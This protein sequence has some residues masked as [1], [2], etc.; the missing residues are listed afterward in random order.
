MILPIK[1]YGL[2]ILR[3]KS[4][5]ISKDYPN[6]KELIDDMFQTMYA[7]NGVGLSANQIGLP[8]R[9]FV[10]DATPY[11]DE[12]KELSGI[13]K[14]FINSQILEYSDDTML[15]NEGCL[16]F[17]GIREDIRRPTTIVIEYYDE[18]FTYHKERITGILSR[19]IQ[20]EYDHTEGIVFIDKLSV[21][22]KRLIKKKLDNIINGEIKVNYK[23][24]FAKK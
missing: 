21:I 18:N 13:K 2:Q 1:A 4:E 9:L 6:L 10:I 22:R 8:I 11:S 12:E 20:H 15:F 24:N 14:V 5:N 19:I 23:I 7:T 3:T 16:S 17:P